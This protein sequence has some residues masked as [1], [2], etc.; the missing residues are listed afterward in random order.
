MKICFMCD[1][2]LSFDKNA[3]QYK[4]LDWALEDAKKK[5]ADCFVFAGDV[6]ADGNINSYQ[7]FLECM[8]KTGI[9][10]LYIPGNS[11]LRD[12]STKEEI[13]YNTSATITDFKGVMPK[14]TARSS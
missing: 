11:D 1:L 2:H 8:G 14:R 4:V 13:Y 9:P 5:K 10:Y 3:L 12:K 7:Y 6:T